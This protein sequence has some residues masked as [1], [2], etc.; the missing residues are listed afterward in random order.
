ML[1][2][3]IKVDDSMIQVKKG[4]KTTIK[5]IAKEIAPVIEVVT[6]HVIELIKGR[7]IVSHSIKKMMMDLK[8]YP[9]V[10]TELGCRLFEVSTCF[11]SEEDAQEVS[12]K[13]LCREYLNL[14]YSRKNGPYAVK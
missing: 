6:P 5:D 9:D 4:L 12:M 13:Q 7:I 1:D 8:I 11:N 14:N 2:T 3:L 10:E